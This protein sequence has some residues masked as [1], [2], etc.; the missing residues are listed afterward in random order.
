MA[1]ALCILKYTLVFLLKVGGKET[2]AD[3]VGD[4]FGGEESA[5]VKFGAGQRCCSRDEA[6]HVDEFALTGTLE[7]VARE[8]LRLLALGCES[9]EVETYLFAHLAEEGGLNVFAPIDVAADS[10]V[11]TV[12]LDVL[13]G[14]A[15]LEEE[16]ASGVEHV[17]MH[18]GM[19]RLVG[20][21]V[22]CAAGGLAD[23]VAFGIDHGEKFLGVVL[24]GEVE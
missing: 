24:H 6:E 19:Q 22:G 8:E 23:D 21:V 10:G 1:D 16:F 12:G 18:H 17:E 5:A 4:F 3:A 11:P 20:A 15:V 2:C 9:R 13:P 7:D 14:G